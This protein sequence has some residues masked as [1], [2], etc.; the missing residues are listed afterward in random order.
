M[1]CY[2]LYT[3][4]L[5]VISL[6][7]LWDILS[8]EAYTAYDIILKSNQ[9]YI[10]HTVTIPYSTNTNKV[11]TYITT[12]K[13]LPLDPLSSWLYLLECTSILVIKNKNYINTTNQT[14]KEVLNPPT[15]FN[16]FYDKP[17]NKNEITI[18]NTIVI[19]FLL[20][21]LFRFEQRTRITTSYHTPD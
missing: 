17:Y 11:N 20:L 21:I 7:I 19:F 5:N 3:D 1:I 2:G 8:H 6:K 15:I 13:E 14:Y 12:I 4:Y 18:D 16:N 9:T 10:N